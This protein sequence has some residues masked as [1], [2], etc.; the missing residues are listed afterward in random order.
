VQPSRLPVLYAPLG[1]CAY[2]LRSFEQGMTTKTY[3]PLFERA[4]SMVVQAGFHYN[5]RGHSPMPSTAEERW[6]RSSSL[7]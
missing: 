7:M 4:A 2:L 6:K 3:V 5:T 1:T